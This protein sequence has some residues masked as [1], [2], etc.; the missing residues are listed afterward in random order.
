MLVSFITAMSIIYKLIMQASYEGNQRIVNDCPRMGS[1]H[2][3][4]NYIFLHSY[5]KRSTK[6]YRFTLIV[7]NIEKHYFKIIVLKAL[8]SNQE[9]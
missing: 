7:I 4:T 5:L 6:V 8:G 2:A 3:F 1:Q 9:F